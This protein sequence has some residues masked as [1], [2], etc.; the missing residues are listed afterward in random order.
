MDAVSKDVACFEPYVW[1][2]KYSW[3]NLLCPDDMKS[4]RNAFMPGLLLM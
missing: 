4:Q 2:L 1:Q 3:D